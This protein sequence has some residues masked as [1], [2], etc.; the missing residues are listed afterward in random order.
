MS[1]D[2]SRNGPGLRV[3]SQRRPT[4]TL[5]EEHSTQVDGVQAS[6]DRWVRFGFGAL[7]GTTVGFYLTI[8]EDFD[9][10]WQ[11]WT[12]IALVALSCGVCS[13]RYG[14]RFWEFLADLCYWPWRR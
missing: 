3:A 4:R 12:L 8:G 9:A 10:A 1:L 6:D 14:D 13:A 11:I 5:H 7:L 2:R